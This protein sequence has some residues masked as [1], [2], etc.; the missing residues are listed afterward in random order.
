[1]QR[2]EARTLPDGRLHLSHGP[3]DLIISATG[4]EADCRRAFAAAT[5]RFD[6]VLTELV[7]E[8][9]A[10]RRPDA[11]VTGTVARRMVAAVTPH[12]SSA[13]I[14]PM[15]AVAGSVADEI[16]AA[17]TSAAPL[18]KAIVN[19]GGDIALML[20][21]GETTTARIAHGS[22]ATLGSLT[23]S[24][25][26]GIGGIATSGRHGRSLSLGIADSVTVLARTAAAADA[27]ATLIANAVDCGPHPAITRVP[28]K[29][30]DPDSDLGERLVVTACAHLPPAEVET[31]LTEGTRVASRMLEASLINAA[32]LF[33]AGEARTVGAPFT[34]LASPPAPAASRP[35][36]RSHP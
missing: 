25:G 8:L 10:L 23:L 29:T 28:A 20:A 7:G 16:L 31:A 12:R 13:F 15:A 24:A 36:V 2:P 22:G 11:S 32:A 6:T 21:P 5:A 30:L 17:M 18:R 1:M 4:G 14:T 9:P 33:L 35:A 27:A 26:D 19:N 3:I 34:V